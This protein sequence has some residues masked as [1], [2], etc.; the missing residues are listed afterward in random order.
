MSKPICRCC[1]HGLQDNVDFGDCDIPTVAC[2]FPLTSGEW[3]EQHGYRRTATE[4]DYPHA[5]WF[6]DTPPEW[7]P[8]RDEGAY[9]QHIQTLL[10]AP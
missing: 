5:D 10:E 8:L 2:V 3:D 4:P 7:C 1:T 6:A 9:W